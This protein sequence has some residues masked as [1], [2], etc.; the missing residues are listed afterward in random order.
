MNIY[1][2]RRANSL[3]RPLPLPKSARQW[4]P[5]IFLRLFACVC[6]AL[7]KSLC[8]R[9][10]NGSKEI[11]KILLLINMHKTRTSNVVPESTTRTTTQSI[12][13]YRELS[14]HSMRN[15]DTSQNIATSLHTHTHRHTEHTN[16]P[17]Y[18]RLISTHTYRH[19]YIHTQ[20][21]THMREFVCASAYKCKFSPL[22]PSPP[23][24]PTT[25]PR[26]TENMPRPLVRNASRSAPL[27]FI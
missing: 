7:T 10:S 15:L 22:T 3:H 11:W 5:L 21:N 25:V 18:T 20:A 26:S 12:Y 6:A 4:A 8:V 23:R 16:R 9:L 1:K 13:V 17:V 14:A 27:R 19:T 2:N 24:R